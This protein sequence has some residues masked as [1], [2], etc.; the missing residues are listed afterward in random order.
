MKGGDAMLTVFEALMLMVAFATLVIAL[1]SFT[2][3]K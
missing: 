1:L 3:K 2:H